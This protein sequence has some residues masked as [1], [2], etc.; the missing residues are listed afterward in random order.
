MGCTQ[1][2]KNIKAWRFV[3]PNGNA[4]EATITDSL[5][6]TQ[7]RAQERAEAELLENGYILNSFSFST[8]RTDLEM[9]QII[10]I[11]GVPYKIIG[12]PANVDM[13]KLVFSITVKRYD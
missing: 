13:K 1:D 3:A 8:W 9:L 11:G 6:D 7:W 4:G 5:L 12:M 10:N 2:I